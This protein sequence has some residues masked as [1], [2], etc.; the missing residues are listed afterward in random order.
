MMTC[1]YDVFEWTFFS[2]WRMLDTHSDRIIYY[3]FLFIPEIV[4]AQIYLLSISTYW[5]RYSNSPLSIVSIVCNHSKKWP[6]AFCSM[7]VSQDRFS[8]WWWGGGGGWGGEWWINVSLILIINQVQLANSFL[9]QVCLS[10]WVLAASQVGRIHDKVLQ[11][12]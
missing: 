8:W 3:I 9:V 4:F 7:S 5:A 11:C 2:F 12:K 6:M 1:Y 10:E